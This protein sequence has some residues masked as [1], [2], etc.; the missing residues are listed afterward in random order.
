VSAKRDRS[1]TLN[2]IY[3]TSSAS[4]AAWTP[5]TPL[6]I[7]SATEHDHL[8]FATRTGAQITLVWVR[9]DA[10]QPTPWTANKADV[11]VSSSAD[12]L[13]WS[14]PLRV[15]KDTANIVHV[16]PSVYASFDQSWLIEWLSTRLG[17]PRVF[18]IPLATADLYPQAVSENT[19]LGSGYSHRIVA[20]P[21]SRVYLGV[22]VQGPEGAQDIY[23]RYFR[24]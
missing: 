22:W 18:E 3:V 12:G 17:S 13:A 21:T 24:R 1:S 20:T 23:Y 11:L 14:T 2:R 8:P 6:A 5:A 16:F 10:S 19:M 7:A 15:T 9:T 4:G